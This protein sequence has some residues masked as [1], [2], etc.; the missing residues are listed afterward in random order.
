MCFIVTVIFFFAEVHME[1]LNQPVSLNIQP[2]Q[3]L[4]ISCKS[5]IKLLAIQQ[6]GFDNHLG[7]L[8]SGS[9]SSGEVVAQTLITDH[10]H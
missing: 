2:S 4:S 6:L 10:D 7:K 9:T 3:S 1:E 5:H 8:W